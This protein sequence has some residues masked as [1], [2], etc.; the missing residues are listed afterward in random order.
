[1]T[2]DDAQKLAEI[3]QTLRAIDVDAARAEQIA[4]RARDRLGHG[5]SIFRF[6]EPILVVVF[7]MSFL[8]WALMKVLDVFR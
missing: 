1:M 7:T 2:D 5:P 8:V 3:S 4:F 6:G